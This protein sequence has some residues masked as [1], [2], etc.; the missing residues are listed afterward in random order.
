MNGLLADLPDEQT[1]VS[2]SLAV[3]VSSGAFEKMPKQGSITAKD[4]GALVNIEP[5]VI[6]L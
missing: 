3:M 6:G 2:T 5:N 4:L 1:N